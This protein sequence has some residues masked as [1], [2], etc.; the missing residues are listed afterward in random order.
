MHRIQ[1]GVSHAGIKYAARSRMGVTLG[2]QLAWRVH[3]VLGKNLVQ[4][5]ATA[6]FEK[7]RNVVFFD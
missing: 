4:N 3:A 6:I 7:I 5:T 1:I 2:N